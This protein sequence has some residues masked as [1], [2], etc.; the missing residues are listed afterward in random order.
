MGARHQQGRIDV[1]NR[2]AIRAAQGLAAT[3]PYPHRD[4]GERTS[5]R[6]DLASSNARGCSAAIL[7]V[8]CRMS[9]LATGVLFARTP[10]PPL[11]YPLERII[12]DPPTLV[13]LGYEAIAGVRWAFGAV[14]AVS[15]RRRYCRPLARPCLGRSLNGATVRPGFACISDK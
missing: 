14:P 4:A 8:F 12:N 15:T 1:P 5:A 10:L 9:D 2:C 11:Q 6:L 7:P 3:L 13:D